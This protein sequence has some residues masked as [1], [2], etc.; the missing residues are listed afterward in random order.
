MQSESV[1]V[2]LFVCAGVCETVCASSVRLERER[3]ER[4]SDV[5]DKSQKMLNDAKE[6][7]RLARQLNEKNRWFG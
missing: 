6:F 4:I 2:S 3:G 1:D 5:A 7:E